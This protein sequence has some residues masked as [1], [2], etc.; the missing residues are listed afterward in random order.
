MYL[1]CAE[2]VV[3]SSRA[4]NHLTSVMEAGSRVKLSTVANG[5]VITQ[6]YIRCA[7]FF[8]KAAKQGWKKT[9]NRDA[10]LEMFPK[11]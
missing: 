3:L 6:L 2:C 5:P 1:S 9:K 11:L 7:A 8:S 4:R 10:Q